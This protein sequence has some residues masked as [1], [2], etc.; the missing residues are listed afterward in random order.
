MRHSRGY[1]SG[2]GIAG[3]LAAVA[4]GVRGIMEWRY[5]T[6]WPMILGAIGVLVAVA[7]RQLVYRD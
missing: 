6:G 3:V 2:M 5:G 1:R 7:L 4:L